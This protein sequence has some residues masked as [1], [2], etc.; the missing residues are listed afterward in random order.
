[1]SQHKE[2]PAMPVDLTKPVRRY[3]VACQDD[4]PV[5]DGHVHHVLHIDGGAR[6]P[7][8]TIDVPTVLSVTALPGMGS[9]ITQTPSTT[10]PPATRPK[11]TPIS[12]PHPREPRGRALSAPA[13]YG[14]G[15][16]TFS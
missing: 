15:A 1:M 12:P 3:Y 10:W 4:G 14:R 6:R 11:A 9:P 13:P 16:V 2:M 7:L 5:W 8:T